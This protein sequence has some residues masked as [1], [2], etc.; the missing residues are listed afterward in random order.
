MKILLIAFF[1]ALMVSASAFADGKHHG[2]GPGH[3]DDE[4]GNFKNH[5]GLSDSCWNAFLSAVS[6]KDTVDYSSIGTTFSANT[7]TIDSLRNFLDSLFDH[8]G[9]RNDSTKLQMKGLISRIRSLV[10]QNDSLKKLTVKIVTNN[11]ALFD[12]TRD[13]CGKMVRDTLKGKDKDDDH[14]NDH[15]S[16]DVR[17]TTH[18]G[19]T[20]HV[21]GHHALTVGRISP[22]PAQLGATLNIDIAVTADIDVILTVSSLIGTQVKQV[23]LGIV[24]AGKHTETLDL[25]GI[26]SGS[27]ILSIQAGT[28]IESRMIKI[29]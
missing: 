14:D 29:K 22:N 9:R 18:F 20:T 1:I 26:S 15:D 7:A 28:T 16:T 10:I 3:G 5:F 27:Y 25:S 17:D 24:T 4:S 2:K 23:D 8:R 6:A 19:D 21:H 11:F 13:N 12:S